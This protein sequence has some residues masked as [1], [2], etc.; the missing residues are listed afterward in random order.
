M[1]IYLYAIQMVAQ[2]DKCFLNVTQTD[3]RLDVCIQGTRRVLTKRLHISIY[4][5][6]HINIIS[7]GREMGEKEAQSIVLIE[8]YLMKDFTFA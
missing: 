3:I 4:I 7:R 8:W 5:F 2:W 6:Y 1:Y